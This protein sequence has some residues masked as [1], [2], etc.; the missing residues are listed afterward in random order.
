MV[1]LTYEREQVLINSLARLHGLPYLNKV[2][3]FWNSLRPPASDLQ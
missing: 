3:V 1:I 2:V